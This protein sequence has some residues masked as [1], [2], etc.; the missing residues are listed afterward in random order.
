MTAEATAPHGEWSGSATAWW[1]AVW[2]VRIPAEKM[3]RSD[4]SLGASYQG[5]WILHAEQNS[6]KKITKPATPFGS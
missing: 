3:L 2:S 1:E 6:V 4:N 5:H